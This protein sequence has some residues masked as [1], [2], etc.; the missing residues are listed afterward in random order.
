MVDT[1]SYMIALQSGV[2]SKE[3]QDDKET[4]KQSEISENAI[5]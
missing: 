4:N 5:E 2:S 1:K 3:R